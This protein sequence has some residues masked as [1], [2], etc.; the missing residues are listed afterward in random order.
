LAAREAHDLARRAVDLDYPR[1]RRAG[2]EMQAV[3]VLGNERV[4]A[5]APLERHERP[6]AVVGL[7]IVHRRFEPGAPGA[8]AHLGIGD[9][10]LDG[11]HLLGLRIARPET[12]RAAKIWNAGVG[13][14]AGAGQRD[15]P[16]RGVDPAADGGEG[17]LQVVSHDDL[18]ITKFEGG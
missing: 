13:R 2:L 7:A 4:E 15:D 9:V 1:W 18:D 5:A 11:R 3:D 17:T 14:D 6:V 12:L 10:V 8:L 16:S